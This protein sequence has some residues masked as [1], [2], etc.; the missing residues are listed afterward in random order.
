MN[1]G[2]LHGRHDERKDPERKKV[3]DEVISR[4]QNNILSNQIFEIFV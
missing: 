2:L 4:N 3:S 1:G